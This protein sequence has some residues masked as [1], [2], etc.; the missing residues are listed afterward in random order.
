MDILGLTKP[1]ELEI[2]EERDS[3]MRSEYLHT[4]DALLLRVDQL[5]DGINR[6]GVIHVRDGTG[7]GYRPV[8]GGSVLTGRPALTGRT[9]G[10]R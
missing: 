6:V 3:R 5:L 7:T 9:A 10:H 1:S 8:A 2:Q 4:M